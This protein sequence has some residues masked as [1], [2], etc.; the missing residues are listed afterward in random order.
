MIGAVQAKSTVSADSASPPDAITPRG[1]IVTIAS[2]AGEVPGQ[3]MS[4]YC[5][6][7]AAAILASESLHLELVDRK[8]DDRIHV[9]R[10]LPSLLN[11]SMF[12]G[13]SYAY[14]YNCLI[15]TS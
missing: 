6:S 5:A 4:D 11:T 2:I 10:I 9:T 3:G 7:K 8:L 12:D 15:F 1:H 13:C 14:V